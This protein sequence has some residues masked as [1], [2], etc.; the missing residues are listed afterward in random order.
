LLLPTPHPVLGS[1]RFSFGTFCFGPFFALPESSPEIKTAG[2]AQ[3]SK[4]FIAQ[5]KRERRANARA[6]THRQT[7][8]KYAARR[9]PTHTNKT[10]TITHTQTQQPRQ[11]PPLSLPACLSTYLPTRLY[12]RRSLLP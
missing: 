2:P 6:R 4:R 8:T 9:R 1:S 5:S 12:K 3:P 10:K 11:P 7:H